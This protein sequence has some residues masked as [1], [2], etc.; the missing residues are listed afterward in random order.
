[1]GVY[2][3]V[4]CLDGFLYSFSPTGD[5]KKSSRRNA[6]KYVVQ[7]GSFLDCSGF[8]VYTSQVEMEG[9]VSHAAGEYIT[10]SA[11]QPKVTLLTMLVPAAGS[12]YWSENN[13]DNSSLQLRLEMQQKASHSKWQGARR[14]NMTMF[15]TL[16][17]TSSSLRA[18][19]MTLRTYQLRQKQRH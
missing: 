15:Y 16:S 8:A 3:L 19:C 2:W 13:P 9:K 5:L 7:V 18:A 12:I 11:I 6:E 1:M 14:K 17:D 10:V 4:H